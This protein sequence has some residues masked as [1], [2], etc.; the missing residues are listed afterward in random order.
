MAAR[1]FGGLKLSCHRSCSVVELVT[2]PVPAHRSCIMSNPSAQEWNHWFQALPI[3]SIPNARQEIATGMGVATLPLVPAPI[4]KGGGT[5]GYCLPNSV[6]AWL[7]SCDWTIKELDTVS[8]D[9]AV[10]TP[11]SGMM[12]PAP[13]F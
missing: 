2:V 4:E 8:Q 1:A 3:Q 7:A 10:V 5:H 13:P 12:T 9:S 11:F 6:T